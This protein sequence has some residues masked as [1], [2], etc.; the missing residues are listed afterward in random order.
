MSPLLTTDILVAGAGPAGL[1]AALSLARAGFR[2]TL[3]GKAEARRNGH[4]VALLGGSIDF[5]DSLGVGEAV[6]ARAAAIAGIRIIDDT[7]SLFTPPPVLF[8]A[9]DAGLAALGHNIESATL[10]DSLR[11]A[12]A[13]LPN[14]TVIDAYVADYVFGAQHA[15]ARFA[16]GNAITASL[17]VAADGRKSPAR[18]AAGIKARSWTY[19]QSALTALVAHARPHNSVSTEF[20]TR[21]GPFTLVPM[22][23]LP[24]APHR[25]S[26]VWLMQPREAERRYALADDALAREIEDQAHCSFGAMRLE[27]PRGQTPMA[28]MLARRFTAP[29]LALLGEA[30]HAFPPVAAQGLNLS[31]RDV[32]A[33]ADALQDAAGLGQDI[34]EAGALDAYERARTPDIHLRSL[35]VDGL[36][37]ALLSHTLPADFIRG[38]G[39]RLLGLAGPLRR[40][41]MRQGLALPPAA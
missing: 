12:L 39:L 19:P 4:T 14:V 41:V 1:A 28:G 18:R 37:R 13:V 27:G 17:I 15:T 29:R 10:A 30:A 24:Y 11:A 23:P 26:L 34:G 35:W 16:N 7:G 22:P 33:L 5:L 38:A 6:R 36:N 40:F 25:S 21:Q 20:Q 3:A 31:L 32:A 9:K 8:S 2:V